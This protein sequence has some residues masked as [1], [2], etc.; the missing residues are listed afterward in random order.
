MVV[1]GSAGCY[2]WP[3]DRV[4]IRRAATPGPLLCAFKTNEFFQVLR[5]KL[6]WGLP[7]WPNRGSSIPGS[8]ASWG[9]PRRGATMNGPLMPFWWGPARGSPGARLEA[10]GFKKPRSPQLVPCLKP[11]A[12]VCSVAAKGLRMLPTLPPDAADCPSCDIE[13][14]KASRA[15]SQLLT[16][17]PTTSWLLLAGIQRLL[18]RL[19]YAPA[20]CAVIAPAASRPTPG[21][22]SPVD[23]VGAR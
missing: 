6:G 12:L 8:P 21:G 4:L 20:P 9:E 5:N 22:R 7:M 3:E 2:V 19:S 23:T 13:T 15:A 18:L 11:P 10:S 16:P 14:D 1:D 17:A